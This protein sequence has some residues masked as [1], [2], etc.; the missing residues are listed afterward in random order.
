MIAGLIL[1]N[2]QKA[3]EI[4]FYEEELAKLPLMQMEKIALMEWNEQGEKSWVLKADQA[5]QLPRKIILENVQI[6]LLEEGSTVS[7]GKAKQ[8]II[9]SQSSNIWLGGDIYV[10]SHQEEIELTTSELNWNNAEK[11]LHT[12]KEVTIRKRTFVIQ[13]KGLICEPDLSSIIIQ[14]QVTT[15]F[16]GGI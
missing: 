11:K 1:L 14:E 7:Q 3:P 9:E 8:A 13:G 16:E 10:I 15:Y 2:L 5:T 6:E 4:Y 12:E